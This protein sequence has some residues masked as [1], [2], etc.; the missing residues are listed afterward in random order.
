MSDIPD[1]PLIVGVM[2]SGTEP[3]ADL[4]GPLGRWLAERGFWLLTGG[5]AGVMAAVSEAFCSVPDRTGR[6]IGVL[7]GRTGADG[8]YEAPPGYPNPWVEVVVR[9]HLPDSGE[10]GKEPSSRN[11]INV[12]TADVI[13]A[14][15]GESGT[16][17]EVELALRYGRPL[18]AYLGATGSLP[19]LPP[20]APVAHTLSEVQ[21]F[22]L[23]R[24]P[25]AQ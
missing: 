5:G 16:L 7:P 1:R 10:K 21:A 8:R 18:L 24:V 23:S 14:L 6:I 20:E 12:L 3:H 2:G 13:V 22:I 25:R 17:S 4:A 15:P 9:T 11:H 19:G